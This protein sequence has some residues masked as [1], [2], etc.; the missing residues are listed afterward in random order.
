MPDKED[1][2][3]AYKLV[4]NEAKEIIKIR[5]HYKKYQDLLQDIIFKDD[6]VLISERLDEFNYVRNMNNIFKDL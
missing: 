3:T 1:N 6:E 4:F 2:D 5:Q